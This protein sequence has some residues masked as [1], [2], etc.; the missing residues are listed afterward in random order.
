MTDLKNVIK[1]IKTA[2]PHELFDIRSA[3]SERE[4][5]MTP[6]NRL[7]Q[8][9]PK[10]KDDQPLRCDICGKTKEQ[11]KAEGVALH[12][13]DN[14]GWMPDERHCADCDSALADEAHP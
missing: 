6:I 10:K 8:S 1:F 4:K 3:L 13:Y 11:L 12:F 9:Y 2:E 5:D 14:E 7:L